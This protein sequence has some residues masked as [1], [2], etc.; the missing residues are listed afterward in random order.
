MIDENK[1]WDLLN[2][3]EYDTRY[4]SSATQILGHSSVVA[5]IQMGQE[6]IPL[7]LKAMKDN[8]HVTFILH[9]LT[10]EWPVK[11]EHKGNGPEIIRSW[12]K[13]AKKRGYR[14]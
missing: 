13:W 2:R 1:F 4:A 10:G 9:K 8:F 6:V 5:I 12:R 7:A 11:D 14:L 3:W